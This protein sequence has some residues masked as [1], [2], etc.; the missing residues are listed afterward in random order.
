M[1]IKVYIL[2]NSVIPS[3]VDEYLEYKAQQK[4]KKRQMIQNDIP[5]PMEQKMK[6]DRRTVFLSDAETAAEALDLAGISYEGEINL[7]DI[8]FCKVETQQKC[9]CGNLHIPKL[10]DVLGEKFQM[11][12]FVNRKN[13]VIIDDSGFAEKIIMRIINNRNKPGQSRERFLYSFCV[14]FMDNDL[15]NLGRYER[16]IMQLEEEISEG[17]L[18]EVTEDLAQLRKELLILREYYDELRD[19]GKE[20]E[21]N[22]NHFFS[23]K[24]LEYFGIISDRADRLMGRTMYLLDYT[25][26]VRDS[27]QG[28]VAEQQNA[29]MQFLTIISAIFFP[30]TL[31]T[32][33]YGMNFQNMPELQNGYPNVIGLSFIVIVVIILIFKKRKIL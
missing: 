22:E 13:I 19:F 12:F 16:R 30:L 33:W 32:G 5:V 31:I 8:E 10:N 24:N 3:S 2:K 11:Y 26:Q 23:G 7:E 15:D 29:N 14:K 6:K 28:K 21:E 1:A 9:M 4:E 18:D 17:D 25:G 27:Y 20:L